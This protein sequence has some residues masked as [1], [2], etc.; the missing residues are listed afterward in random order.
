MQPCL[1]FVSSYLNASPGIL[2]EIEC[3]LDSKV[4]AHASGRQY[5]IVRIETVMYIVSQPKPDH[6]AQPAI[7]TPQGKTMARGVSGCKQSYKQRSQ[8][9]EGWKQKGRQL[10]G[11]K[12]R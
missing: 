9:M 1:R 8:E 11:P 10:V 6:R 12:V 5:D 7:K 4:H 2:R 3:A